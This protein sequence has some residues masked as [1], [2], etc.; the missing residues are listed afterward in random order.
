MI[1]SRI[2]AA[3]GRL[4]MSLLL[5]MSVAACS[6]QQDYLTGSDA[7]DLWG[8]G[9][10]TLSSSSSAPAGGERPRNS[11]ADST[12]GLGTKKLSSASTP[13]SPGTSGSP[14]SPVQAL[15][16][17]VGGAT[18]SAVPAPVSPASP[19]PPLSAV[20]AA[21]AASPPSPK[22]DPRE[23]DLALAARAR[24]NG[25]GLTA[26]SL[27]RQ[28]LADKPDDLDAELG[29]AHALIDS[30]QASQ[31][32]PLVADLMKKRHRDPAVMAVAVRLDLALGDIAAAAGHVALAVSWA[33]DD[34]DVVMAQ[35]MVDDMRGNHALAERAYR[36]VLSMAPDDQAAANNLGLAL[37]A[38]GDPAGALAVLAPL[39]KD[40]PSAMP[41]LRHNLAM[42]YGFLGRDGEARALLVLDLPPEAVESDMKYYGWLRARRTP[43]NQAASMLSTSQH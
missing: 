19:S 20:G 3:V 12:W 38:D 32:K 18:A 42:A 9:A 8:L 15:L 29:L 22:E 13:S 17:P 40:P 5:L 1:D 7:D 21:P 6:G 2:S 23:K 31:A 4:A 10:R 35:G 39:A 30:E 24:R 25:D 37:M 33:P 14:S 43:L 11:D 26:S 28:L 34:R 41:V 27:Y 36:K 16:S